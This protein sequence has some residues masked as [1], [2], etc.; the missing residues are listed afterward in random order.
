[1]VLF[2]ILVVDSLTQGLGNP[3]HLQAD[4]SQN[5]WHRKQMKLYVANMITEAK[6]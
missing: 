4:A 5:I 6:V 3:Q 2:L 1:M